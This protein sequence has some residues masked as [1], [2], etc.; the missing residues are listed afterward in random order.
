LE[1][2]KNAESLLK[3]IQSTPDG[4][5]RSDIEPLYKEACDEAEVGRAKSV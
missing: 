2:V 1:W 3:L 5:A 4:V